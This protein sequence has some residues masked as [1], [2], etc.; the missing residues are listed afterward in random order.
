MDIKFM[1][2]FTIDRHLDTPIDVDQ[3]LLG[4]I[5]KLVNIGSRKVCGFTPIFLRKVFLYP[6]AIRKRE[7]NNKSI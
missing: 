7:D 5:A 4:P 2:M 6:V 1:H 3:M